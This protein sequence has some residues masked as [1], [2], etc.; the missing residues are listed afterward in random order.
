MSS[1]GLQPAAYTVQSHSNLRPPLVNQLLRLHSLSNLDCRAD[2]PKGNDYKLCS[3]KSRT[4][5]G[6]PGRRAETCFYFLG[7]QNAQVSLRNCTTKA[8]D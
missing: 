6:N 1:A 5:R 7:R 2:S 4:S 8:T 3:R